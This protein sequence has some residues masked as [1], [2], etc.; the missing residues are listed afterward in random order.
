MEFK[1]ASLILPCTDAC[2]QLVRNGAY[3]NKLDNGFE[4]KTKFD[5]KILLKN[6][7]LAEANI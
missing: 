7:E 3:L 2:Q 6:A 1:L 4:S 5:T